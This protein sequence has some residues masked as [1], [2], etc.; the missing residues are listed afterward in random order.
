MGPEDPR[1]HLRPYQAKYKVKT[2]FIIILRHDL[3]ILLSF[4]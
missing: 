3:P 1:E 4:G 2:I